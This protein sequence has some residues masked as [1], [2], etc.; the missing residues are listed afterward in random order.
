M[1]TY[2]IYMMNEIFFMTEN[3]IKKKIMSLVT[4]YIT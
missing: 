4:M 1:F 3:K 2:R